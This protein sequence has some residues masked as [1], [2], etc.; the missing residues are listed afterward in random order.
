MIN[1]QQMKKLLHILKFMDK[2]T[3]FLL[4][5]YEG[6]TSATNCQCKGHIEVHSH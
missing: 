3:T 5:R 1:K 6:K 2:T 4:Q